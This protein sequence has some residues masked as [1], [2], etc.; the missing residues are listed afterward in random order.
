[1]HN[2]WHRIKSYLRHVFCA[3]TSRGDGVHSPFV[4]SFI[5]DVKNEKNPYY[6]YTPIEQ[7][8]QN[9]L[10]D[11]TLLHTTDYGTGVRAHVLYQTLPKRA[12]NPANKRNYSSV[13]LERINL[14]LSSI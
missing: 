8:R 10:N 6:A 3:K 9:L 13:W 4:F 14:R 5:T 11:K 2:T 12:L 7:I 1:M